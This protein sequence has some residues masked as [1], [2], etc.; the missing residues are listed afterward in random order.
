MNVSRVDHI[1][2]TVSDLGASEDFYDRVMSA[3]DFKK[4]TAPIGGD[5]HFHYF[6]RYLQISIRPA[7]TQRKFD[8]YAPGLH[9]ICLQVSSRLEVDQAAESLG[10]IGVTA[11]T[12][13]TYPEYA[14]DYYATFFQDPDGIRFEIVARREERDFIVNYWDKLEGFINPVRKLKEKLSLS[15]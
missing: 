2:L 6:N 5:P 14:K 15:G 3:L 10:K 8:P 9:H 12:P 4:G 1:Y 7:R 11:S 13:H